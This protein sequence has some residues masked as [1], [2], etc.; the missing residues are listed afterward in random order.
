MSEVVLD[1]SAVLAVAKNEPGAARVRAVRERA[2]L[3]AVNAAEVYAKLL[4]GGMPEGQVAD[5][6]RTIIGTVVPFDDGQAR[7]AA[8]LHARTRHLGLSLGDCVC[9]ALGHE[10]NTLVLT[11]DQSWLRVIEVGPVEVIR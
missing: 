11:A 5:G 4:A 6:L 1:A 8:A 9:L 7:R 10:R 3:S 2:V